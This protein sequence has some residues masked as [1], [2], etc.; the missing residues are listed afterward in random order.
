MGF[1]MDFTFLILR[2]DMGVK[3]YEPARPEGERWVLRDFKFGGIEGSTD[4]SVT[5]NIGIGYPF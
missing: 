4:N 3:V 1:R 2:L 5:L